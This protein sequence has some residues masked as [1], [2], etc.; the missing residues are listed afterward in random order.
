MGPGWADD[1]SEVSADV[2]PADA[3]DWAYF[4]DP[5]KTLQLAVPESI[6]AL[7]RQPGA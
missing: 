1:D 2:E 5:A 7:L 3:T 6:L 4:A